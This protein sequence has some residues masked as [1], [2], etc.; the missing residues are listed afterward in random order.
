MFLH[1]VKKATK[2][3]GVLDLGDAGLGLFDAFFA[4]FSMIMVSD[5]RLKILLQLY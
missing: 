5:V 2:G 3:E 1:A 4:S